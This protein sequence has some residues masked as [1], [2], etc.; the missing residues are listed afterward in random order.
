M[1]GEFINFSTSKTDSKIKT[2]GKVN[3]FYK[4]SRIELHTPCEHKA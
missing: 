1:E 2:N 3:R 4:N